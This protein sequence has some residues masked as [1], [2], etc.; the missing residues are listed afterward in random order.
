M[1]DVYA[2]HLPILQTLGKL[3]SINR[4]LELGAG[5]YSTPVFLDRQYYPDLKLLVSFE[6]DLGW[7]D[8]VSEMI[9]DH[10]GI[11]LYS[12]DMAAT[13]RRLHDL[14]EYQ[15]IFI[16]NGATV[17]QR[18]EAIEAVIDR[19][20]NGLLVIHDWDNEAYRNA[21]MQNTLYHWITID[22]EYP[23]TAIGTLHNNIYELLKAQATW[24]SE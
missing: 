11:V 23:S 10:R 2:T 4:V 20:P 8:A 6:S 3:F 16:D 22:K 19:K 15:L 17:S 18:V 24:N 12:E 5:H 13:I 7:R 9:T 1:T 21:A 14:D